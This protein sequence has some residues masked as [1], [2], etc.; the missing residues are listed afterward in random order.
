MTTTQAITSAMMRIYTYAT[1]Q[2]LGDYNDAARAGARRLTAADQRPLALRQRELV[3]EGAGT[4]WEVVPDISLRQSSPQFISAYDLSYA[5]AV[6]WLRARSLH[7][8]EEPE[9]RIELGLLAL[10]LLA[11]SPS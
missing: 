2:S 9:E 4:A 8:Y 7:C 1:A 11:A 5:E 6:A 3:L 10:G